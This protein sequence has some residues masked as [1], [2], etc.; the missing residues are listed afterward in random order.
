M[1]TIKL[2]DWAILMDEAAREMSENAELLC[3]MDARM[4]DGDLGLTM[5]KGYQALPELYRALEDTDMGKR[6]SKAG[7]KMAGTVPSTM[8]TLMASGWMEGGKRLA[9]CA[10]V[11]SSE[12]AAF[13]R[14]FAD[15]IAK[16]GKCAV[17]DRTVLD[18]LSPAADAAEKA[19]ADGA[20]LTETALAALHGAR[21]GLEATRGMLPRFGK[22]AV[23]A[24]KAAG[25]E[26][27]GAL[28]GVLLV[29]GLC[30]GIAKL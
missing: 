2:T 9:G 22:A 19:A 4:G 16:R 10:E 11:G 5:R 12:F 6:L 13:L 20:E 18:A 25:T 26:D 24:E 27:Q 21:E 8:G 7:M 1:K 17:G 23:F 14:G 3:E 30:A 28:A 15:G 29:Q